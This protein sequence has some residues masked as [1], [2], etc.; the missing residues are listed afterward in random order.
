MQASV[1]SCDVVIKVIVWKVPFHGRFQIKKRPFG[2]VSY[3]KKCDYDTP[4]G[5]VDQTHLLNETYIC[6]QKL[7]S[8]SFVG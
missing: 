5:Q 4:A 1:H 6:L 8:E 7:P 3:E 2:N